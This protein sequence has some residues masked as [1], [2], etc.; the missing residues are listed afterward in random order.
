[1]N[2]TIYAT[3][4]SIMNGDDAFDV[5]ILRPDT[6]VRC[7]L[8]AAGRGGNPARHLGL[9]QT[10]AAHG[11]LVVAPHFEMLASSIPTE[12]E[13][14]RRCRRLALAVDKYCVHHMPVSGVG[15]SIGT[16]VLL[17][18]AGAEAS[19]FLGDRLTF[20]AERPFDRLVLLAPPTD[21]FRRPGALAPVKVPVQVWAGGK[22]T[23]TPP[24]QSTLLEEVLAD[25]TYVDMRLVEDAGHFTFMNDLPPN[26]TDP[27]PER[28]AFLQS[29]GEEVSRFLG[30]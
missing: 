5:T 4:C 18:H 3:T 23:I 24:I 13:L 14:M 20:R 25:Q 16:V 28:S 26:V 6:A 30:A 21:F 27:H 7:V 1:M 12:V 2:N 11:A 15:H 10:L 17:I 8:F 22:D 29:L 19:T 9:L